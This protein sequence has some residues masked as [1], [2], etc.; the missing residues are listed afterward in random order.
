M[1]ETGT[2]EMVIERSVEIEAPIGRVWELLTDGGELPRWWGSM[3]EAEVDLVPGGAIRMRWAKAEHGLTAGRVE[4]AEKPFR[5]A[6]RWAVNNEG[7]PPAPGDQTL[8]EFRLESLGEATRVTVRESGF[9]QLDQPERERLAYL[10]G[11]RRGWAEVLGMLVQA[12]A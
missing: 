9:D 3:A 2:D 7:R 1:T 6:F 10:E 4:T 12:P 5:F 8:V 11:N